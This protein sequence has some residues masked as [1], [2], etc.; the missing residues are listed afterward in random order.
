M[1]ARRADRLEALAAQI[2]D[3]GGRAEC[4]PAGVTGRDEILRAIAGLTERLG[5]VDLLVANAGIALGTDGPI[6]AE[7]GNLTR[8]QDL[9]LGDNQLSGP[10]PAE[11]GSLTRLEELWLSSNQLSG[12]I[13][14]ELGN[15]RSLTEL[16]VDTDTGL[17]LAPDFDLTSP[18]AVQ[19]GLSV[20]A[21]TPA[22]KDPAVV[23]MAVE[24][25]IAA[26]TNGEGLRTG[27]APVTVRLD[28]LFTF[29]PSSASAV[30]YAGT[31]FSV[32]S[33]APGVV[34]VS[35]SDAGPGVV[36]TPG[37][38]AGVPTVTVDARPEGQ[39]AAAP[40]A[41]VM[42]EVEVHAAVPALPGA[43][44]ALLAL[45]LALVARRRATRA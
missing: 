45:L 44:V 8:L 31:T 29:P 27:G 17:C 22:P 41:S 36:L 13:P 16:V 10:I 26:A 39:P 3:E 12:E 38:D 18:F 30:T 5:P 37:A 19:S 24:D 9:A 33:T 4:V 34:S 15:L 25:A 7:L 23:Q 42:F 40:V 6:P 28:A 20:C 1:I 32:S 43:A 2:R 21:I 11:L 35:T 14:A